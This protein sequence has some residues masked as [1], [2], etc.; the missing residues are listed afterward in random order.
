MVGLRQSGEGGETDRTA[1]PVQGPEAGQGAGSGQGDA[2]V[3]GSGGVQQDVDRGIDTRPGTVGEEEPRVSD[4]H[5]E[6]AM[7]IERTSPRGRTPLQAG[8]LEQ[9]VQ[10]GLQAGGGL[11]GVLADLRIHG[12]ERF[13]NN[14]GH[15]TGGPQGLGLHLQGMAEDGAAVLRQL[16]LAGTDQVAEIG[17]VRNHRD[18]GLLPRL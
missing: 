2:A 5:A 4:R 8:S 3:H 16:V 15:G 6:E 10:A 11:P 1:D 9:A 14:P 12:D 18:G 7:G 13:G 17:T